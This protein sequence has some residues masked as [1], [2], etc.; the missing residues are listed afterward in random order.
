MTHPRTA[1][2]PLAA[3]AGSLGLCLSAAVLAGAPALA[4][5]TSAPAAD[6][7][8]Q[9]P[10]VVVMD[11][12]GSMLNADADASGTTRVDAAKAATKDLI[13][14]APEGAELG[15]VTFGHRRAEDCTDIE[16]I[17]PVG[18]VDKA[19]L[20]AQVDALGA[21]GETPI[22]AALQ[23]AAAA[24]QG[25]EKGSIVLVSDG[26]PSCETPPAC[27]VAE[28]LE[29]QGL[30]LT[31]HTI[32]FRL[33]GN[34]RAQETLE[35]IAE[36]TGGTYSAAEDAGQLTEQLTT[37]TTRAIQG[38]A[39]AGTPVTGGAR[40]EDAP[41]LLPGQYRDELA[42]HG[43]NVKLPELNGSRFDRGNV[44]F[45]RIPMPQGYVPVLS[46]TLAKTTEQAASEGGSLIAV[47]PL[48]TP[49]NA[50]N[51]CFPFRSY[52]SAALDEGRGVPSTT[53][54]ETRE[55][56]RVMDDEKLRQECLTAEGDLVVAVYQ[57]TDLPTDAPTDLEL[58]L[59]YEPV[60]GSE[61]APAL[62]PNGLRAP[63]PTEPTPV[64][65]G[66]SFNDALALE[67]GTTIS[68]TLV[69]GEQRYYTI[70]A[71]VNQNV[72]T[73]LDFPQDA[74][75]AG[76]VMAHLY[77]PLRERMRL[78]DGGVPYHGG[79][80]VGTVDVTA[81]ASSFNYLD[82]AIHPNR[83]LEYV[84][85]MAGDTIS[86]A[87][88]QYVVV[89]RKHEADAPATPLP[90][91]LT[92][93]TVGESAGPGP[94]YITTAAQFTE[95]FGR[96]GDDGQGAAPADGSAGE[97]AAAAS[98]SA[99][100]QGAGSAD[101]SSDPSAEAPAAGA[102]EAGQTEQGDGGMPVWAWV[103]G[104]VGVLAVGAG[105]VLVAGSRRRP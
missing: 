54:F 69:P 85:E 57:E 16:T 14:A 6:Q 15:L 86:V 74:E 71:G 97:P 62:D 38:Y 36:A 53:W 46:A 64:T 95:K 77:N 78:G 20:T 82:K 68:D 22:S 21:R 65:G 13:Q 105:G 11:H 87:G 102:E 90:F 83:R 79:F 41:L 50:S 18:P 2:A 26:E 1:P 72:L 92:V 37:Q 80:A 7:A 59:A 3:V 39:A 23:Q 40:Y 75:D 25:K 47:Q 45:Y 24:L 84:N 27:E 5:P 43:R 56:K 19:A 35:C 28:S 33:T 94:E 100:D 66:A 55:V 73:R 103:L 30:D 8:R 61:G 63:A 52:H 10:V 48:A 98:P 89:S 17:Q 34:S 12:S 51:A 104:G 91:E 96:P 49:G 70:E 99:D 88:R 42:S 44:K 93:A 101:A 58:L 60:R 29:R 32:G 67:D 81:G 31:V 76:I 4:A 9:Q